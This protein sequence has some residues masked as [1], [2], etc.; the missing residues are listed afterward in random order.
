MQ[1]DGSLMAQGTVIEHPFREDEFFDSKPFRWLGLIATMWDVTSLVVALLVGITSL[2]FY[3][4]KLTEPLAVV[5]G[6]LTAISALS[7]AA[8]VFLF[9]FFKRLPERV[10]NDVW[11]SGPS[12][13]AILRVL[14][15]ANMK[16]QQERYSQPEL[17]EDISQPLARFRQMIVYKVASA[18]AT[19]VSAP[20]V[21]LKFED[22]REKCYE[23][24]GSR[25]DS[26]DMLGE[27]KSRRLISVDEDL[28]RL[29]WRVWICRKVLWNRVRE[30]VR[31]REKDLSSK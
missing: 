9:I 14:L 13:L 18:K 28:I 27:A 10:W 23:I 1:T 25:V 12:S 19:L 24:D 20:F 30:L 16:A 21:S 26:E 2:V 15:D 29:T 6:V 5:I 17:S 3:Q 11:A 31:E 22:L 4:D 7:V 8:I